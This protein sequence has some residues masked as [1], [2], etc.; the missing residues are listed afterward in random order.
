LDQLL[1]IEDAGSFYSGIEAYTLICVLPS[2]ATT[3]SALS[4]LSVSALQYGQELKLSQSYDLSARLY[5]YN[6]LPASPYWRRRF[7]TENSL[8][9]YL[10]LHSGGG[11]RRLLH[12]YWYLVRPARNNDVWLIWRRRD[13]R[14]E[15]PTADSY[16]LYVSP[17]CDHLRDAFWTVVEVLTEVGASGFKIGR[18]LYG[19]LRPDKLVAYFPCHAKLAEAA[20]RLEKRLR[21]MSAHGV[22]FTSQIDIHGLLSWG[23]DPPASERLLAW[24]GPSWRRWITDQLAVALIAAQAAATQPVEPW[25]FAIGRL[26]LDGVDTMFWKP[27][28]GLWDRPS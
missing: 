2:L 20:H 24:H 13:L 8:L 22:P 3:H 11:K 27:D 19:I 26:R 18:D 5:Y 17:R 4:Q 9:E 14:G 25:Q 21:G 1:E 10:G 28:T 15:D 7:P 6:R 16:K 12:S 23:M